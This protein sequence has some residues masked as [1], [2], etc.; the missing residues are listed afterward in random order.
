M[1]GVTRKCEKCG[2]TLWDEETSSHVCFEDRRLPE[3][4][5]GSSMAPVRTSMSAEDRKAF[6]AVLKEL[7]DMEYKPEQA[8]EVA[9]K[10][11]GL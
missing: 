1:A 10:M 6:L 2:K 8:V 7:W 11:F 3:E 9:C 5:G 4:C